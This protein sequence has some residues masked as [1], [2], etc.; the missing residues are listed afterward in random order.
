MEEI[1][2]NKYLSEMGIC[3]RREA[4]RLIEAGKIQVD[5][6]TAYMGMKIR[7]SQTV[8]CGGTEVET[9]KGR[10]SPVLLAVNKPKGIVCTTSDKD[11]AVNI[12]EMVKYPER[13]YPVGRLDK[14]SEGL[15]FLTNQGSLVNRIMKGSS[16][17]EK[18]YVVQV[19]KAITEAFVK[20]MEEGVWLEELGVAT[21][22]CKIAVTG[23]QEF[24][25][26]LTQ[27][28]NRQIRRMCTTQGY[29]VTNLRRIRIMNIHLG[30][31]KTGT[32]RKVTAKEYETLIKMLE[33]NQ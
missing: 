6:K 33:N 25:I 9:A 1:R 13:V 27:G 22:P 11:R 30:N 2:L 20:I 32:Y 7:R 19:N 23:R 18:E 17:H 21:K 24:H 28:L 14:D 15:I 10:P 8:I 31:L 4:D 12:V 26:I 3:S 5:G 16:N 29:H